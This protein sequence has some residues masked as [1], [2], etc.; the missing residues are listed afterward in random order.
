MIRL[1]FLLILLTAP[2]SAQ[3]LISITAG[4]LTGLG[5]VV[6]IDILGSG[7]GH[8]AGQPVPPSHPAAPPAGHPSA[9]AADPSPPLDVCRPLVER[10]CEV[11]K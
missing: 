3:S 4:A 11:R 1:A 6:N 9:P 2:A 7:R 8:E 10:N 5:A